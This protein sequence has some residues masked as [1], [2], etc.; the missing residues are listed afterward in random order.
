MVL[1]GNS[2]HQ[3]CTKMGRGSAE[4]RCLD[5]RS[6]SEGMQEWA[7]ATLMNVAPATPRECRGMTDAVLISAA[8]ADPHTLRV[9]KA[10]PDPTDSRE[11]A[12]ATAMG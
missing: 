9:T 5:R 3:E 1:P 7:A 10:T 2:V 4:A 12:A 8:P 6:T 11:E